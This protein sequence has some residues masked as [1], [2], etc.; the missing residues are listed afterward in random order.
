MAKEETKPTEVKLN[1]EVSVSMQNVVDVN[2]NK[3]VKSLHYLTVKTKKGNF[4][5]NT[6][7]KTITAVTELLK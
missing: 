5:I 1:A 4:T 3:V 7:A 6:G 2:T